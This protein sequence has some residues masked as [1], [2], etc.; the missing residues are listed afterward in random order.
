MSKTVWIVSGAVIAALGGAALWMTREEEPALL[1][2]MRKSGRSL[3]STPQI[4]RDYPGMPFKPGD[5]FD[6]VEKRVNEASESLYDWAV[7]VQS[8]GARVFYEGKASEAKRFLRWNDGTKLPGTGWTQLEPLGRMT[9]ITGRKVLPNAAP[10]DKTGDLGDPSGFVSLET[11]K[12]ATGA[13]TVG[14]YLVPAVLIGVPVLTVLGVIA[15]LLYKANKDPDDVR[16]EDGALA[17]KAFQSGDQM[18]AVI[19]TL[20][21]AKNRRTM[22]TPMGFRVPNLARY[23]LPEAESMRSMSGILSRKA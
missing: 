22:K 20:A 15:Y 9:K 13:I 12:E 1:E 21:V 3:V 7:K 19:E 18:G 5:V 17:M 8:E 23:A 11:G 10:K 2:R 4:V 16:A 6:L 14:T